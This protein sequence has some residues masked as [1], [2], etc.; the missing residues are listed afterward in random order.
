[1]PS[2]PII[3][4]LYLCNGCEMI[5][6]FFGKNIVVNLYIYTTHNKNISFLCKGV[7]SQCSLECC[8]KWHLYSLQVIKIF[9]QVTTTLPPEQ[10][11]CLMNE[12]RFSRIS[13]PPQSGIFWFLQVTKNI[14][15]QTLD[16]HYTPTEAYI[17]VFICSQQVRNGIF[18]VSLDNMTLKPWVTELELHERCGPQKFQATYT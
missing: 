4:I 1:M 16:K 11:S 14:V 17:H 13:K 3:Y 8:V 10:N 18:Q 7:T 15:V 9:K 12:S 2:H 6:L 5:I